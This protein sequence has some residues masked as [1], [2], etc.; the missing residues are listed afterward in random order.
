MLNSR[1]LVICKAKFNTRSNQ[2]VHYQNLSHRISVLNVYIIIKYIL[3]W[4]CVHIEW[5]VETMYSWFPFCQNIIN[6]IVVWLHDV[7]VCLCICLRVCCILS[8]EFLYFF[9]EIFG[10][11]LRLGN[12]K[13]LE[14]N[15]STLW[16]WV[17]ARAR[18]SIRLVHNDN[19]FWCAQKTDFMLYIRIIIV[20]T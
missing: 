14:R 16:V 18:A 17:R 2:S 3:L 12:W 15:E 7:D 13:I 5:I 1:K 6:W 4:M 11:L 9:A 10:Y 19:I 20:H 8:V